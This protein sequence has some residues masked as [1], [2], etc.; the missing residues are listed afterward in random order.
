MTNGSSGGSDAQPAASGAQMQEARLARILDDDDALAGVLVGNDFKRIL[1]AGL[2][3]SRTAQNGRTGGIEHE[4]IIVVGRG[5]QRIGPEQHKV[6]HTP[7]AGQG[8][9]GGSPKT[10]NS[11]RLGKAHRTAVSKVPFPRA[12]CSG[13][14]LSR[15]ARR[16]E[17]ERA[18]RGYS[19]DRLGNNAILKWRFIKIPNVINDYVAPVAVKV[20]NVLREACLTIESGGEVKWRVGREVVNYFQHGGPLSAA[21][22]A[23]LP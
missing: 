11:S 13:I 14:Q 15:I 8:V 1:S 19:V 7:D 16:R 10:V 9:V 22:N 6:I 20:E 3:G 4:Q 23:A 21:G 5:S 18:V 17:I 12:R 2:A